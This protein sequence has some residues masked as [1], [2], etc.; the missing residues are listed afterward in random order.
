MSQKKNTC[1]S[2]KQERYF[3]LEAQYIICLPSQILALTYFYRDV[4]FM[5][6]CKQSLAQ[7]ISY[8]EFMFLLDF[9]CFLF[10]S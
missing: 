6:F 8:R 2:K 4:T 10:F 9:P 3:C 7:N 1:L 5:A